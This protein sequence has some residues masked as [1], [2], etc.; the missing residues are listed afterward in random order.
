MFNMLHKVR[1]DDVLFNFFFG[2]FSVFFF[3]FLFCAF[4]MFTIV[5]PATALARKSSGPQHIRITFVELFYDLIYAAVLSSFAYNIAFGWPGGKVW[6]MSSYLVFLISVLFCKW[7]NFVQMLMLLSLWYDNVTFTST[8]YAQDGLSYFLLFLQLIG[9]LGMAF[10]RNV[11]SSGE[12]SVFTGFVVSFLWARF[13]SLVLYL[14]MMAYRPSPGTRIAAGAYGVWIAI[15]C[16][17]AA[18]T[19]GLGNDV[20][21]YG[22]VMIWLVGVGLALVVAF[23]LPLIPWWRQ[24]LPIADLRHYKVFFSYICER[25]IIHFLCFC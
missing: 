21:L 4:L 24:A 1:T 10:F 5:S 18:V 7:L 14:T 9:V 23:V 22:R 11:V 19:I 17:P 13:F 3:F 8:V 15:T 25:K 2:F 12:S 20:S 6:I 16:I